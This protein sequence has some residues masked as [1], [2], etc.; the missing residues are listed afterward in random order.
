MDLDFISLVKDKIG[1]LSKSQ[2]KVAKYILDNFEEALFDTAY[3][4]AQKASVSEATVIRFSYALGFEGYTDMNNAMRTSALRNVKN[5]VQSIGEKDF[6]SEVPLS[7]IDSYIEKQITQGNRAY[8]Y[9]DFDEFVEICHIIMTKKKILII[10]Y[11]DSF[12]V[13]S[14]L[15]HV[16]EK[17]RKEVYFFRL[18]YRERDILYE[19]DEDS[20]VIAVSFSPHY[21]YTLDHTK[22]AKDGG[23]TVITISDSI[24]NPFNDLSDYSLIFNVNRNKEI[25]LIDTSP[26]TRFIFLMMNYIYSHY[27]ESIDKYRN[28]FE[29]R[30]E[31][32]VE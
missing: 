29:R 17:M 26:V 31:I 30:E 1:D 2:Q 25:D 8:Q 7:E 16:L 9:I 13:A 21:K 14:E 6:F 32:Y 5:I 23:C 11:M 15:L 18:L 4:L 19:M 20:L 22:T 12:G 24:I 27:K 3:Q 28:S 10:G